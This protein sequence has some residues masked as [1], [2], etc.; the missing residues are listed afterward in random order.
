[1]K[2]L[3]NL[4]RNQR[5]RN[6]ILFG[7]KEDENLQIGP[8]SADS[9]SKKCNMLLDYIGCSKEV[10]VIDSF[11]LGRDVQADKPR[12]IKLTFSEKWMASEILSKTVKLN[13]LKQNNGKNIYIK[14]DKTKGEVTEFQRLGKEKTKLLEKY[15]PGEDGNT[16]VVLQKG[17]LKVDG[18]EVDKYNPV[19]TLF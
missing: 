19:Q 17:S 9:D 5:K 6:V 8:N 10:N 13:E 4:D 15:P 18:V 7:V 16:R 2:Y 12:P 3:I 14:P 11:R 1:M